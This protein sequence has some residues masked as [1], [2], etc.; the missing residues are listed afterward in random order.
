MNKYAEVNRPKEI[1]EARL[2]LDTLATYD[3]FQCENN[4][5]PDYSNVSALEIFE[6]GEWSD[7][8]N[9]DGKDIDEIKIGDDY[10][11]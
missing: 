9:E 4:I 1:K 8:C 11:N 7:W 3:L 10:E 6:N 5:K 2:I